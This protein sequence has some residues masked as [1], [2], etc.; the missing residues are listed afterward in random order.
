M[1]KLIFIFLVFGVFSTLNAQFLNFGIKGG[2]NYNSNGDLNGLDDLSSIKINSDQEVGYHFGVLAEIKL[3]LWLYIRPELIYTHTE[4]GYKD[5]E[6]ESTLSMNKMDIPV[7][8]GIRV[9]K[10]GRIFVGPSFQYIFDTDFKDSSIYDDVRNVSY[11]DFTAGIQAGIGLEFGK[12][13][14]DI[15]WE[16]PISDSQAIFVGEIEEGSSEYINIDTRSEQIIFSVYYKF[17]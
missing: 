8:L 9:L 1:K 14:A 6:F 17:K 16:G 7:L 10:I 5:Q 15:R 2:V 3:P 12:I 13:G 11:D 4:S